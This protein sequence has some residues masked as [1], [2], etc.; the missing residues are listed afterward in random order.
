MDESP[1]EDE[2]SRP[3]EHPVR[4]R[5]AEPRIY[6]SRSSRRARI[7]D[8]LRVMSASMT[9]GDGFPLSLRWEPNA[10]IGNTGS[11]GILFERG[12][13]LRQDGE[14]SLRWFVPLIH[15]FSD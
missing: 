15:S 11:N 7:F 12:R 3:A 4:Q 8:I 14:P 6:G 5:S 9:S 13:I 10:A 2:S 1:D